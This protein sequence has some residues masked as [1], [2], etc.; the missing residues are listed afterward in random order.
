MHKETPKTVQKIARCGYCRFQVDCAY[1]HDEHMNSNKQNEVN[2]IV[3][4]IIS[5]HSI[6]INKMHEDMNNLKVVILNME[7]Q[8]KNLEK[9]LLDLNTQIDNN[10]EIKG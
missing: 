5:K 3:A 9:S 8:I 4:K 6:E 7:D 1:K 10:G 2:K